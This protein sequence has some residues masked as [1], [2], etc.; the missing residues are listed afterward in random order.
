MVEKIKVLEEKLYE[1]DNEFEQ[2]TAKVKK[3]Y[4]TTLR[5]EVARAAAKAKEDFK[6]TLEIRM[7]KARSKFLK[8]KLDFVNNLTGEKQTELVNLRLQEQQVKETNKKL[9]EALHQ[10]E[11][12]LQRLHNLSAKKKWWPF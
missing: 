7:Q 4:D 2:Q 9:E 6:Y 3:Q 11:E 5:N 8:E 12:E 10:S 1:M